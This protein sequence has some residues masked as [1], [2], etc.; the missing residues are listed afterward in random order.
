FLLGRY[1]AVTSN[2]NYS[3]SGTAFPNGTG[4]NRIYNY[5]E[6]ELYMQDSWKIRS[7][8]TLLMGLRWNYHGVPYEINGYQSVPSVNEPLYF[9]TRV[10]NALNGISGLT[11]TPLVSYNLGG[12]A[13]HAPGYYNADY[14]DFGPR[15]ALAYNPGFQH[16]LLGSMFGERKTTLRLGGAILYDRIAGGA[17]FGL[18]QNTFLF[19]SQANN[20]FSSLATDPRFAGYQTF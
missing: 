17:S 11:A 8:L 9:S 15:L 2:F 19:D 20:P 12:P 3:K 10:N 16:G 18:D 7:D 4:K 6:Y 1:A 14:K 5:N 13:N